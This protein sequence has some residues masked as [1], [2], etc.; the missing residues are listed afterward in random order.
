[1]SSSPSSETVPTSDDYS[2]GNSVDYYN[3]QYT[4]DISKHMQ[5]P[6]RLAAVDGLRRTNFHPDASSE[7]FMNESAAFTM[8]MPE[9]IVLGNSK[10]ICCLLV[11]WFWY[12]YLVT[13]YFA[14]SIQQMI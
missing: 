4:A 1:M 5:M 6:D 11:V 3:M 14:I 9:K 7:L 12:W 10:C 13:Y 2:Y 8:T